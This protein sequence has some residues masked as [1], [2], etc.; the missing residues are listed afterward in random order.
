[1]RPSMNPPQNVEPNGKE[2]GTACALAC[3]L[4]R[5]EITEVAHPFLHPFQVRSRLRKVDRVLNVLEGGARG[6]KVMG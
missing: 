6:R 3:R 2:V 4:D 1:M 5:D